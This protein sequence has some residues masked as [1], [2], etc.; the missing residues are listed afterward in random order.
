MFRFLIS[1]IFFSVFT[2]SFAQQVNKA[3][4]KPPYRYIYAVTKEQAWKINNKKFKEVYTEEFLSNAVDSI[5]VLD[6]IPAKYC[7]GGYII[8]SP[9]GTY[10]NAHFI[11]SNKIEQRIRRG[12]RK[13]LLAD[14]QY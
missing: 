6:K 3:A 13:S 9:D 10:L 12:L 4:A 1:I 7:K 5:T 14:K 2:F 11:G 8:L